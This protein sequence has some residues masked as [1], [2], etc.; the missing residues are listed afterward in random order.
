MIQPEKVSP[1]ISQIETHGSLLR[2][3]HSSPHWILDG[4]DTE[5]SP[6]A[7]LLV[8]ILHC[9]VIR[10]SVLRLGSKRRAGRDRD[11]EQESL[12]SAGGKGHGECS[13]YRDDNT[14]P[15]R[16]T[17]S[18]IVSRPNRKQILTVSDQPMMAPIDNSVTRREPTSGQSDEATDVSAEHSGLDT[19]E[20]E[21]HQ[22]ARSRYT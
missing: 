15:T 2:Q 9:F 11:D 10:T 19:R 22:Q 4:K 3:L 7:E 17:M 12:E 8:V 14:L 20:S 6:S 21:S 13:S 5:R 18:R 1:S 16:Q